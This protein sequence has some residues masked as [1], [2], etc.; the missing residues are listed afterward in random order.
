[1]KCQKNKTCKKQ[2]GNAPFP[3]SKTKWCTGC[4]KVGKDKGNEMKNKKK[5]KKKYRANFLYP[6]EDDSVEEAGYEFANGKTEEY[7]KLWWDI[8]VLRI[9]DCGWKNRPSTHNYSL[10]TLLDE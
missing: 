1:M 6:F 2:P 5:T 3:F 9:K 8:L 10:G 4:D 7:Q